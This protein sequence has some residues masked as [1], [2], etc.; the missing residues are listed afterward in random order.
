MVFQ[1]LQASHLPAHLVWV[2]PQDWQTNEAEDLAMPYKYKKGTKMASRASRNL[3]AQL[4]STT[5][6]DFF[7]PNRPKPDRQTNGFAAF[8]KKHALSALRTNHK[9]IIAKTH[10]EPRQQAIWK[11]QRKKS[12]DTQKHIGKE[13]Y[14]LPSHRGMARL[15]PIRLSPPS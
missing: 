6:A 4:C 11:W 5:A 9:K 2:E 10:P 14:E 13:D 15:V 8:N 12:D 3:R 1:P 7:W